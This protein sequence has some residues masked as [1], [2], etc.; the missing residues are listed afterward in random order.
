M[1]HPE[2]PPW[3]QPRIKAAPK[4]RQLYWCEFAKDARLPE[5]WKIR[6]VIVMSY[7]NTLHGPCLVIPTTTE[8]QTG[9]K[10]AVRLVTRIQGG[11]ESWAIC[12]HPMTVSPSR[13]TQFN[14]GFP[15]LSEAEFNQVLELL[16]KWLPR[17]FAIEN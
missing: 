13:F 11:M 12:N 14:E 17:P 10:W 3:I 8:P 15:L 2:R 1:S 9:N 7:S 5:M 16:G 6:P 4:I